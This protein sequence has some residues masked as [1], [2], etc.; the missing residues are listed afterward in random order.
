MAKGV[1]SVLENRPSSLFLFLLSFSSLHSLLYPGTALTRG[2]DEPSVGSQVIEGYCSW[3]QLIVDLSL[4]ETA[5]Y[6]KKAF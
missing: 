1:S 3:E 2:A 6:K 5:V 4:M